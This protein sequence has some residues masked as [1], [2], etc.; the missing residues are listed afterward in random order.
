MQTDNDHDLEQRLRDVLRQE[1]DR[2]HGPDPAWDESPAARRVAEQARRRPSRWTIRLLAVAAL[3]TIGGGAALLLGAPDNPPL[4]PAANG[5]IAYGMHPEADDEPDIWLV[6]LDD[7]PRRAV[8]MGADQVEQLCPA[9]SPDGHSLAW[10][11]NV[12]RLP[13]VSPTYA[14]VVGSVSTD[15]VVSETFRVGV[16]GAPPCPI[17]SPT[18]DRI[19]FGVP[20][21]SVI[22]PTEGAEGSEV[23]ILTVADRSI[24]VLPDL[25]A[26]D[27]EFS[28]DG[29]LLGI[30]SGIDAVVTG[31]QLHDGRL[32]LYEFATGATRTLEGTSGALTFT[33]SPDGERIAYS[34]IADGAGDSVH[35]MRLIDLASEE[36]RELTARFGAIHGIGPVWSPDGASI[37]YQRC[38]G[39]ACSGENHE[40]VLVWPEDVSTEGT[41]REEVMPLVER[42]ADGSER[43]LSGPYW[44]TWSPDG[45][46]L[47]FAAWSSVVDPLMGVV[48]AAPG[49]A[50]QIL[51]TEQD[52]AVNPVYDHGPFV[53]IQSWG[54]RPANGVMPTLAP[55]ESVAEPSPSGAGTSH[56]LLDGTDGGVPITVSVT[57]P[58][59][60]GEPNEGV[61]CWGDPDTCSGPPDSAGIFAFAS[62]EYLVYGDACHQPPPSPHPDTI[63]TTVDELVDAMT[64][65]RQVHR[66]GSPPDDITVDGYSGKRIEL[67]MVLPDFP[68][69]CDDGVFALFGLPG[70]DR[71]RHSQGHDQIEELW[72][73]DVDGVVVVLDGAY[74]PGTPQGAVDE[75]RAIIESATFD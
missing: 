12:S 6:S 26:T 3:I 47:L 45:E 42:L 46:Y 71:A 49:S 74:Y 65:D 61:L 51:V 16:D 30:A 48:P 62:R 10:G 40:V 44:V 67:R 27:L 43:A 9:F 23:W 17:W 70:D 58:G 32:L 24:T 34:R 28:P 21:T 36:Q 75:M 72:A 25:L 37:V 4:P 41:P 19:A 68:W 38:R 29:S 15:G 18:G 1:L 66:W 8:G 53:P 2:D 54:R 20:Q 60:D 39:G 73:L 7:E 52:V 35:Q 22:N 57:A 14:V 55:E 64:G 13:W 69:D 31:N 11:E 59:W 50:V 33:W 63:A 56:L 5:W